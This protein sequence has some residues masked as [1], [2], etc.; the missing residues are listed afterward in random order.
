MLMRIG[1][2]LMII[3]SI[4]LK[5][6]RKILKICGGKRWDLFREIKK[7]KVKVSHMERDQRIGVYRDKVDRK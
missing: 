5:I 3:W 2:R 4:V 1:S 6:I 7:L